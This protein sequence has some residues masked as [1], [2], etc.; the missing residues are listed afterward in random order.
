MSAITTHILDAVLG[1]PGAGIPLRLEKQTPTGWIAAREGA[2]D[3]DGRCRDL[4]PDASDGVYRLTFLI[5]EYFET[6]GRRSIYPEIS[7]TFLIDGQ[8]HYHLPLLLSD[9]SYTTY[10]GS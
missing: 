4:C 3:S 5:G 6:Q 9:N 10:R 7:I 2:T 1:K 8:P